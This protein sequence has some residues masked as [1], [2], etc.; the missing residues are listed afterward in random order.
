MKAAIRIFVLFAV[1]PFCPTEAKSEPRD[2]CASDLLTNEFAREPVRICGTITDACPDEVDAGWTHFVLD[3]EGTTIYVAT[4]EKITRQ[5]LGALIGAEVSITG[6]CVLGNAGG[7][8]VK[9]TFFVNSTN[10]IH[11][12]RSPSESDSKTIV[13][14]HQYD[15]PVHNLPAQASR[16][17]ADGLVI[18][19][20]DGS[21][22]LI[23]TDTGHV[24]RGELIHQQLPSYGMRIRMSGTPETDLYNII[25]SRASWMAISG[26]TQLQDTALSIS[27]AQLQRMDA[28][29][30]RYDFSFHGKSVRIVGRVCNMPV[31]NIDNRFYLENDGRIVTVDTGS[32][33]EFTAHFDTGYKVEVTGT[34]VMETEKMGY[35][36]MFT[37]ITGYRIV[38][39]AQNDIRV[40][41]SPP[42]WTPTRL[43]AIIAT[44]LLVL[45]GVFVWNRTLQRVAD[46]RSRELLSERLAHV[47]SELK[48][49]E[50]TRLSV[51]LHDALSQNLTGIAMEINAAEELV[52]ESTDEARKHLKL[53]SRTLKSSRDELRNCLWDLRS[54]ALEDPDMNTAIKKTLEPYVKDIDLQVR[55]N[56]PRTLFTDNTAHVM[57]RIIRELVMNAIQHGHATIIRI[58][59]SRENG[60][61][62]FSV[63]DNGSGFDPDSAPGIDQ[64][65]F[66]LQGIRERLRLIRGHLDIAS[67]PGN[68]T[69][70]TARFAIP[71]GSEGKI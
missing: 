67:R 18:A 33:P 12:I 31:P 15:F 8:L 5:E 19:T 4:K 41:G 53:A 56:I 47:E 54:Q 46:R 9:S 59:G 35:G 10:D 3:S 23:R 21:K 70:A 42:W 55:F 49:G 28:G 7:R 63:R 69:R 40:L 11:V 34:C 14:I 58:A 52:C 30:Q 68:G 50:R 24:V 17:S 26:R 66:G 6:Y 37:H 39:H 1:L 25:L 60:E 32:H 48:V 61:I 27:P 62:L 43:I 2:V 38:I 36:R 22:V 16:V 64:G 29:I 20:W 45:T 65:H 13:D 57:M 71:T 51:E 44:L